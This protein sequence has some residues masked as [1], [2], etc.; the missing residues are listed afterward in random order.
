MSTVIVTGHRKF[1]VSRAW[2]SASLICFEFLGTN[3]SGTVEESLSSLFL[4]M[5]G[6][7]GFPGT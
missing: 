2:L 5:K 3:W 7:F 4:E 1:C 6:F